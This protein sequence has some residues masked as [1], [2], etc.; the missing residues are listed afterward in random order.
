MRH[1]PLIKAARQ[2]LDSR[3]L[4]GSRLA[5]KQHWLKAADA[6]CELFHQ[7]QGWFGEGVR[8]ALHRSCCTCAG[9]AA[10][11]HTAANE[12]LSVA[13]GDCRWVAG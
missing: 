8:E 3:R 5:H 11:E 9:F 4:A 13:Q 10:W 2:M 1:L 12:E 6:G 7:P